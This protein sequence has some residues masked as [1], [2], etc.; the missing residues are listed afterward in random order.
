M[1]LQTVHD[2]ALVYAPIERL[3][4]LSRRVELV[5]KILEMQPV[6]GVTRGF[7][8]NG[9]RVV[10]RGWKFGLPTEHH[11][12]ISGYI[13]PCV[14]DGPGPVSP[15]HAEAAGQVVAWFQDRQERGRFASFQHDH[16]LR[17]RKGPAGE[18]ITVLEDEVRFQLPFSILGVAA[19]RTLM[20]PYVRTLVKRRFTGLKAL[21]E[22][23]GWRQW[24]DET[25]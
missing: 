12:L 21:A 13:A 14:A 2:S 18:P 20:L 1:S 22:G 5:Q 15:L 4:A 10:W 25:P 9:S 17:E 23:E 8:E 19:A 6:G 3:W 16:W 11:T 24:M 7:V